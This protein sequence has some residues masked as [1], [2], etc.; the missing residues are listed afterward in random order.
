MAESTGQFTTPAS[1]LEQLPPPL[2]DIFDN[3]TLI[4]TPDLTARDVE[5]WDS[6]GNVR[7][8]VEVEKAFGLRFSAA[9]ISSLQNLGQLAHLILKKTHHGS[10]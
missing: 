4:A 7:L 6:L 1:I 3:D 5:G 9:E 8:F 10:A 2:R